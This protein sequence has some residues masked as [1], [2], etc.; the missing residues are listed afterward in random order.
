MV[1]NVDPQGPGATASIY[2]G[3]IVI[4]WNGEPIQHVQSVL[5]ALGPDSIGQTVTIGLRRGV[6]GLRAT[7]RLGREPVKSEAS[8]AVVAGLLAVPVPDRPNWTLPRLHAEIGRQAG[9]SISN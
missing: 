5:H 6:D 7:E 4:D 9:V 2:R 1:M 8:A 3:D